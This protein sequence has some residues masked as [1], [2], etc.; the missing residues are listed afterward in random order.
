MAA[1]A[2]AKTTLHIYLPSRAACFGCSQ[3]VGRIILI[4]HSSMRRGAN[5]ASNQYDSLNRLV[6]AFNPLGH[7]VS[8]GY[9]AVGRLVSQIDPKGILT[10]YEYDALGR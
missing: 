8:N 3:N 4:R 2:R 6:R 7:V 10:E 5:V 1:I 9:D